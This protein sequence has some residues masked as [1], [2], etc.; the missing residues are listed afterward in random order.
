MWE[1]PA[2]C[3]VCEVISFYKQYLKVL[4]EFSQVLEAKKI[5]I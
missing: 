2:L 5:L 4:I 3:D 1:N